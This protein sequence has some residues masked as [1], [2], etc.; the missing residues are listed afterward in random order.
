LNTF[1]FFTLTQQDIHAFVVQINPLLGK[2]L[3]VPINDGNDRQQQRID[4]KRSNAIVAF[5]AMN[6]AVEFPSGLGSFVQHQFAGN[7]EEQRYP[8]TEELP[9]IVLTEGLDIT[10]GK[11]PLKHDITG[12]GSYAGGHHKS[13]F[14]ETPDTVLQ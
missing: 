12:V 7:F 10:A 5:N 6:Q 1:R 2:A 11:L 4:G 13:V 9:P 8:V 14:G 3:T